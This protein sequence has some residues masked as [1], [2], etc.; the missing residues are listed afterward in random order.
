MSEEPEPV[1][2]GTP[3]EWA[4]TA[5]PEKVQ[6]APL[7]PAYAILFGAILTA[8][9]GLGATLLNVRSSERLSKERQRTDAA[10]QEKADLQKQLDELKSRLEAA[11][12]QISTLTV[13][14]IPVAVPPAP[15]PSIVVVLPSAALPPQTAPP[16]IP[17]TSRATT[18]P[19]TAAPVTTTPTT[20]PPTTVPV[21]TTPPTT[22]AAT[23]LA[24]GATS[25]TTSAV[26]T[27]TVHV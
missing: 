10:A 13:S 19:T 7:N 18:P 24:P 4:A 15:V 16:T 9:A 12:Q 25:T 6:R 5:I 20:L 2:A 26:T 22:V 1:V 23:T 17:P 27:T 11:N 8:T 21:A 3:D 14:T